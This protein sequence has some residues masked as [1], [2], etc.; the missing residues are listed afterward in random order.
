MLL[1]GASAGTAQT[2]NMNGSTN[3]T[4]IATLGGGCFWCTEAEFQ[5]LP[6]VKSVTSDMHVFIDEF[7]TKLAEYYSEPGE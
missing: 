3:Q 4:E 6:G 5:R 2:K 7:V 1:V